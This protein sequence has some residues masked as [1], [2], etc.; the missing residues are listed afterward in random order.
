[1]SRESSTLFRKEAL[2]EKDLSFLD[3]TT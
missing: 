1:V 3:R 2:L